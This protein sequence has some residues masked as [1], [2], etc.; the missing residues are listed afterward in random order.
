MSHWWIGRGWWLVHARRP[1]CGVCPIARLCPSYG[2][3]ELDPVAAAKL[4][5][6]PSQTHPELTG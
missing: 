4:V 2:I 5:K 1:A 3:G 6:S